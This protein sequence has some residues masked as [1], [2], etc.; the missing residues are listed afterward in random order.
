M[1]THTWPVPTTDITSNAPNR[2]LNAELNIAPAGPL[3]WVCGRLGES[4]EAKAAYEKE[5][6]HLWSSETDSCGWVVSP[7]SSRE[8]GKA[9]V[10]R[11][12]DKAVPPIS[13]YIALYTNC[14]I[15]KNTDE[16][17]FISQL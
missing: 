13:Q 16:T 12:P 1:V 3:T 9:V 6:I 17:A 4:Q 5:E 7:S 8:L 15:L 10:H 14:E 2:G 11:A